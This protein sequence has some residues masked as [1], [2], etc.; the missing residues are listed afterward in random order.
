MVSAILSILGAGLSLWSSKEKTKY[1]DR[2]LKLRKRYYEEEKKDR[3]DH[4]VM[5]NIE[6]ELFELSESFAA[7][8]ERSQAQN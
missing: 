7:A 6:F 8:V 1:Q 2:Y 5:D 3:P 4:A